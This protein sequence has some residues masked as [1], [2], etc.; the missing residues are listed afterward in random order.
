MKI[1]V[2]FDEYESTVAECS[3]DKD[4]KRSLIDS[5]EAMI[6][7]DEVAQAY[8]SEVQMDSVPASA[9]GVFLDVDGKYVFAEFKSGKP[10]RWEI[11]RKGVDSA[12]VLIDKKNKTIAWLRENAE[13]ILVYPELP[14]ASN[15]RQIETSEDLNRDSR[16][17]LF[18]KGTTNATN[19]IRLYT[20]GLKG[21]LYKN[22]YEMSPERFKKQ[23]C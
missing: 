11:L 3:F 4:H 14:T 18:M 6:N 8:P 9:D 22:V 23:Y 19:Q 15:D 16:N 20:Q 7:F 12:I 21:Y 13:F 5:D 17:R 10:D 2:E 1:P